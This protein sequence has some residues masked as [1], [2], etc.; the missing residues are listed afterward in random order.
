VAVALGAA[1]QHAHCLA[2]A[3]ALEADRDRLRARAAR[4][5]VGRHLVAEREQAETRADTP[6]AITCSTAVLPRRRTLPASVT[7]P[8]L[9][10][11]VSMPPI[12]VPITAPLSQSTR[13]RRVRDARGPASR[14]ASIAGDRGVAV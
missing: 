7:G 2:A 5:G 10:P 9:A 11:I 6:L 14:Q 3:D 4:A 13:H 8:T 12:P 1:A